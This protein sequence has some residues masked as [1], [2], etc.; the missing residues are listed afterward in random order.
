MEVL[1]AL[2]FPPEASLFDVIRSIVYTYAYVNLI[3]LSKIGS[4]LRIFA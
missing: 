1:L 3:C 2:G 4:S